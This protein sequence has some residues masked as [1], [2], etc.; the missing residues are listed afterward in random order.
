MCL[1]VLDCLQLKVINMPKWHIWG[2]YFVLLTS[3]PSSSLRWKFKSLP[4]ESPHELPG[5]G[6][7]L[8]W[9]TLATSHCFFFTPHCIIIAFCSSAACPP[10]QIEVLR[11]SFSQTCAWYLARHPRQRNKFMKNARMSHFIINDKLFTCCNK[12]IKC[13]FFVVL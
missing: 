4:P 12:T 5:R 7:M 11:Q 13:A 3:Y 8:S 9:T 2:S 6:C 1:P 10:T